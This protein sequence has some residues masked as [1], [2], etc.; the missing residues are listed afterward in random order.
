M[1]QP[2]TAQLLKDTQETLAVN[3]RKVIAR[4]GVVS[5]DAR[6]LHRKL[7]TLLDQIA[8]ALLA[9]PFV[10]SDGRAIGRTLAQLRYS[11]PETLGATTVLLSQQL[12]TGLPA[13]DRHM[14]QPRL[15]VLLGEIVTGFLRQ[16]LSD[17]RVE[18]EAIHRALLAAR[19]Q[20]ENALRTS[21]MRYRAVVTQATEGIVLVDPQ[22]G[23]IVEANAAFQQ[24]L[25]YPNEELIGVRMHEIVAH[26]RKS[27][28]ENL[29]EA[30]RRGQYTVRER[31]YR[32]KDGALVTVEGSST[33]L[34]TERGELLCI[35]VR[36]ITE[37]LRV[38]AEL[39]EARRGLAVS[40]EEERGH[41]ARELHDEA[42]QELVGLRYQLASVRRR[43]PGNRSA[44]NPAG[45]V[46]RVEG[47]IAHVIREL[48]G[49]IAELRPTGLDEGGLS[50]ALTNYVESLPRGHRSAEVTI[51]VSPEAESIPRPI[52]LCLFRIAQEAVRNAMKHGQA[53]QIVVRLRPRACGVILR[54][55]DNGTGFIVP[56]RLS[57]MVRAHHFGLV[58]MTERVAQVNGRLRIRSRP[59]RGT[60]VTAWA[61]LSLSREGHDD[62]DR[63]G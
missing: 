16:K 2:N 15:V 11:R 48:R 61:P 49:L 40:R 60:I 14:L 19:E 62:P 47:R 53:G 36:D 56:E 4:P 23:R 28:E 9:E 26:D 43:I 10:P 54:V 18:Q 42:V 46:K 37:R 57:T 50:A 59:G 35:I 34:T 6:A 5:L 21:E 27:V 12:L 25:G 3:W 55:S 38:E 13:E 63:T 17:T 52:A 44:D 29:R 31:Q 45:E 41:L 7:V 33:A 39:D 1:N 8:T 20:A 32:R 51:E 22:S 30:V 24:T 58:G